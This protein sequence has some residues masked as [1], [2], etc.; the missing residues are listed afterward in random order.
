VRGITS[1]GMQDE[2]A[3]GL[4]ILT[5]R[6]GEAAIE[7]ALMAMPDDITAGTEVDLRGPMPPVSFH[8]V[9]VMRVA[10]ADIVRSW[11]AL[12]LP[13]RA[14]SGSLH[15]H[16][17]SRAAACHP[18]RQR[19]NPDALAEFALLGNAFDMLRPLLGAHPQTLRS[20]LRSNGYRIDVPAGMACAAQMTEQAA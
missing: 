14:D 15:R 6:S 10:P 19:N 12:E 13:E 4:T 5:L 17:R 8:A 20:L 2:T 1:I 9:R 18:D 3:V 7:A 16:W 11:R